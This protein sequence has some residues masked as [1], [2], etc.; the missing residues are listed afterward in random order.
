MDSTPTE[1]GP[2]SRTRSTR[3]PSPPRRARHASGERP[4]EPVGGRRRDGNAGGPDERARDRVVRHAQAHGR[5]PGRDDPG[6]D[7][8][9]P[10]H[11]RQRARPEPCREPRDA[12]IVRVLLGSAYVADRGRVRQVDDQRVER[13][14]ILGGED[15]GNRAGVERVGP[16]PVD[17]LGGE[18]DQATGAQPVR[19][20][21][22]RPRVVTGQ[23][24]RAGRP[25]HAGRP[26]SPMGSRPSAPTC[27][28]PG[29]RPGRPPCSFISRRI[30]RSGA[31]RSA[32]VERGPC[33]A[34]RAALARR[35]KAPRSRS[36]GRT[37]ARPMPTLMTAEP[38]RPR[39]PSSRWRA[40]GT[41]RWSW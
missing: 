19:G 35:R 28:R 33:G 34:G 30:A 3:A 2:P 31:G 1:H 18:D 27:P 22:D 16:E 36:G 8:P 39:P 6:Y 32:H 11:E 38:D 21:R 26:G 13:R 25:R 20:D 14:A 29:S 15:A 41:S 17:G 9:L 5:E 4:P 10:Q 23:D 40:T 7:R 12:G 24:R 37:I